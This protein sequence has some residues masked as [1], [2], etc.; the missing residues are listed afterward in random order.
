MNPVRQQL[1]DQGVVHL[2]GTVAGEVLGTLRHAIEANRASRARSR[3]VLYTHT[4][5]P[6]GRPPL[7][8]LMDQWLSPHRAPGPCS[9]LSAAEALRPIA[10][11]LL[12]LDP[13]LFQD[14][15]LVKRPGQH[16]FPWHQDAPFWPIDRA[17][18][19]VIWVP[20]QSASPASGG[21]G[22]A[23]G[24]HRLGPRPVIDLHDGHPQDRTRPLGFKAAD[25]PILQPTYAP[26]DAIAFHPLTFH[27]SPAMCTPGERA[28]WSV[29]F[30]SPHVRW[31]HASAPNHPLCRTV[32][33]GAPVSEVYDA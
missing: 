19:V 30:L 6:P 15:L 17:D 29:A 23:V 7:D 33:D 1:G 31:R 3:Q 2:P 21:L 9:T 16:P 25:W 26:G 12:G 18:G 24:S 14:L 8:A 22:F 10:A 20:L 27:G 32:R 28:A 5:E 11:Q 13:V 4:P